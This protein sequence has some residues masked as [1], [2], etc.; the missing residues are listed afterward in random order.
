MSQTAE[1]TRP[2]STVPQAVPATPRSEQE[3]RFIDIVRTH[4]PALLAFTTRLVGGDIGRAEDIVQETFVRAWR[5]IDMLTPEHGSVNSW[6][7]RVASN[8]AID[9]HRMRQVRP[10]EVEL[11]HHDT[12]MR[13]DGTDG[14]DQIL[15]GMVVRD[16]LSSIWPEHRAVLEEV[17][18][19]DR[20]AAEAA[21]VLGIP[22]GT[23]KSRLFYA[24]RTLRGNALESGLRAG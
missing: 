10:S 4:R 9:S 21:A 19:K 18:L 23:V 17:Y 22:V 5:R 2:A 1:L 7:R 14:T 8:V 11:Q 20:T 12:P 3:Q 16:M 13:Q 24:L 6:L 15:V